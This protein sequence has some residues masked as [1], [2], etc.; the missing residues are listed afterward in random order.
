LEVRVRPILVAGLITWVPTVVQIK[1][2]WIVL[3]GVLPPG[4]PLCLRILGYDIV[5]NIR[6]GRVSAELEG[7]AVLEV[8]MARRAERALA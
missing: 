8:H 3:N 1:E 7:I 4:L 6:P 2:N 5:V